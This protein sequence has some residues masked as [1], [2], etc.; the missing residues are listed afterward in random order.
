MKIKSGFVLRHFADKWIAVCADDSADENNMFITLNQSGVFVWE[1]LQNEISYDEVVKVV[2]EKY[3]IT[4]AQAKTE[5]DEF[6]NK[7]RKAGI[8][9]E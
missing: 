4:T 7:L 5:F 3:E 6:L 8:L 2:T 1:L 9:D